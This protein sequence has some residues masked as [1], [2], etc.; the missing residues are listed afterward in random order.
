MLHR[1]APTALMAILFLLTPLPC[2]FAHPSNVTLMTIHIDGTS[3]DGEL[4]LPGF[5]VARLA[6]QYNRDPSQLSQDA[7]KQMLTDYFHFHVE[8]RGEGVEIPVSVIGFR[9]IDPAEFLAAGVSIIFFVELKA[10]YFPLTFAS[11]VFCEF[12]STQ[13]NKIIFSDKAR[14]AYPGS[15]PVMLTPQHKEF[16]F[17]IYRPDFS[18]FVPSF[19]DSDNDGVSDSTERRYGLDPVRPDTDGDGYADFEEI[20]MGWDP[21]DPASAPDQ[22]PQKYRAAVTAFAELYR[23]KPTEESLF[24]SLPEEAALKE[25][26]AVRV[27]A[28]VRKALALHDID[29]AA[30]PEHGY[31]QDLLRRMEAELFDRFDSGSFLFLLVLTAAFGFFHAGSSGAGKGILLGY[32]LKDDREIRHALFFPLAFTLSQLITVTILAL[33]GFAFAPEV[34]DPLGS[35]GYGIQVGAGSALAALSVILIIHA[36]RKIRARI[37][38]GKKTFFDSVW[39]AVVFGLLSGLAFCPFLWG[40]LRLLVEIDQA[41]LAPFF[42]LAFGLGEFVCILLVGLATLVARHIFLDILP[43]LILY[44]E[45][46]SACVM[47]IF[48]GFFFFTYVPF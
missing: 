40:I 9:N 4:F 32:C 38:I 33:I 44:S 18:E 23:Q 22:D 2:A 27:S 45:L 1:P 24:L 6:Q 15:W 41:T 17:N 25:E 30:G 48:S 10:V 28:T 42:L 47:L 19:L 34:R 3:I 13:T 35:V 8:I 26:A 16:V 14:R 36:A 43:R 20:F 37:V 31:L 29:P 5:Q 46:I 12:S 39:G 21:L 7:L 11:D